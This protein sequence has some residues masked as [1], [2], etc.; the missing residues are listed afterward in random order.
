MPCAS[1][2]SGSGIGLLTVATLLT[3]PGHGWLRLSPHR[4]FIPGMVAKPI[5]LMLLAIVPA[6]LVG[7]LA[8]CFQSCN[9]LSQR[10][11]FGIRLVEEF[12]EEQDGLILV[13]DLFLK[14]F[15]FGENFAVFSLS[16]WRAIT[17]CS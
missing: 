4:M 8:S 5:L 7:V 1:G 6:F 3:G 17:E 11:V 15:D 16:K 9:L 13:L 2:V 14:T 12:V 10:L